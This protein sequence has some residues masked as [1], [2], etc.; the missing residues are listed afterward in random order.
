[1]HTQNK[2]TAHMNDF[3]RRLRIMRWFVGGMIAV[4][5]LFTLFTIGLTAYMGLACYTSGDPNSMACYMM[6]DRVEVGVRPR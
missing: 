1:M 5:T 4:V 6:S 3:D 2:G